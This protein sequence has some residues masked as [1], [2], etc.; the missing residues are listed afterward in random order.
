MAQKSFEAKTYDYYF[1]SS[2]ETGKA[3]LNIQGPSGEVCGVWFVEDPDAILP[4]AHEDSPNFFSIYYHYAQ[5]DQ[6]LDML[7]NE[8]P[9]FVHF[10]NDRGFDNSRISTNR[11]PVGEGEES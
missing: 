10:N 6:I 7:R 4:D 11:E 9:V 5:F 3:N 8:K 1:W 2:R